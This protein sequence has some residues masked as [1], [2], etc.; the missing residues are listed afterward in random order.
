MS[1]PMRTAV[2]VALTP[3]VWALKTAASAGARRVLPQPTPGPT[4]VGRL[5]D[6]PGRGRTFVIDVPGPTPDGAHCRAAARARLYGVPQLGARP[7]RALAALPG[8]HPRPALARTRHPLPALPLRRLR[9][10]RGR[11]DGRARGREGGHRGLLDGWRHR[12]ADVAPAPGARG[13]AGA[14][15]DGAQLPRR[16]PR[17]VLLPGAHRCDA[18]AVPGRPHPRRTDGRDA[19]GAPVPRHRRPGCLG[20]GGVPQH[21]CLVDAGGALRARP[22]QLRALDRRGRRADLGRGDRLATTRSRSA[23]SAGSRPASRVRG[24]TRHPAGTPRSCSARRPGCPFSWRPS[25]TWSTGWT[26]SPASRSRARERSEQATGQAGETVT[27]TPFSAATPET[28]MRSGSVRSL[29]ETPTTLFALASRTP[30][31]WCP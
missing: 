17:A 12:P 8:D 2:R 21:Q 27:G 25:P 26:T 3:P 9:R 11:R 15:L 28:S 24:C 20:Q 6:L 30:S 22:V 4:P 18:P 29:A 5:V 13:R 14:V 7:R 23:G 1:R 16:H 10:R 31:S 19:A